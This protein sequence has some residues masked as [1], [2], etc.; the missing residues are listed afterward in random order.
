M[1]FLV[2]MP[3]RV[4]ITTRQQEKKHLSLKTFKPLFVDTQNPKVKNLLHYIW[5]H[6]V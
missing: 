3:L 6:V 4:N 1:F 2:F 5:G